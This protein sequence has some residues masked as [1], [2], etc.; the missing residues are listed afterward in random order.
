MSDSPC[1]PIVPL[2]QSRMARLDKLKL[3]V[4]ARRRA[5][6]HRYADALERVEIQRSAAGAQARQ[7][8]M[9]AGACGLNSSAVEG[10]AGSSAMPNERFG[11]RNQ[12]NLPAGKLQP[13]EQQGNPEHADV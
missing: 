10:L 3:T 4:D 1:V 6:M 13:V 11:Q 5:I 12:G 9:W 7:G 8:A 2:K